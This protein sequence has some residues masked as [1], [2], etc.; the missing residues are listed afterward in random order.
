MIQMYFRTVT[1]Y[2]A[3]GN[4]VNT[5]S[6]DMTWTELRKLRDQEL[7]KNDWWAGK[8][9]TL[10]SARKEYRIFLRDLPQNYESAN[11][12]ADAWAAY[13]IPE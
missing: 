6:F 10:T 13:D 1:N 3:N 5:T 8:D 7:K 11:D 12:A 2:D 9:V 4:I